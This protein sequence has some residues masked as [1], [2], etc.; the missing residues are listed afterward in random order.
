M[1]M[2]FIAEKN[3]YGQHITALLA[4]RQLQLR[5]QY[6]VVKMQQS[7]LCP[8]PGDVPVLTH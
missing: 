7:Q 5:F 2:R 8:A 1:R 6:F 3:S 4:N